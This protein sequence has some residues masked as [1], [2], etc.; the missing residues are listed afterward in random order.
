MGHCVCK[1]NFQGTHCELCAPGFYGPGCQ[2]EC[3]PIPN[4]IALWSWS[5]ASPDRR[6]HPSLQPASVLALECW[7]VIATVTRGSARAEQASRGPPVTAVL[8][9]TST[10]P[11]ASVSMATPRGWVGMGPG[12][13]PAW[14]RATVCL[15]S[16]VCGCSPAGTLP[17]GCDKAGRCPCRP[18]FDGPHC[19]RC[20][21]GH[22]G[23]PDCR[24]EQRAGRGWGLGGAGDAHRRPWPDPVSLAACNCDPQGALDQLCGAGGLCRCRPGYTGATCQECSPGFH[25]FPACARE[26]PCG[27]PGGQVCPVACLH[28]PS[29]PSLPVLC[30]GLPARSLRPPQRAV[31]LPT[32]C[33]GAAM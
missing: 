7:T 10:S 27:R 4:P 18:E 31:Q 25:G 1:P 16:A 15:C 33:D 19:D 2:R 14:L 6:D 22:H 11:S 20:R 12:A 13:L 9:A 21:P 5:L 8:L 23:Y 17:Q 32:P 26:C 29:S 30:R 24:G 28:P 3:S